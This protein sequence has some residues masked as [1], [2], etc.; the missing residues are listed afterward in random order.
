M[1]ERPYLRLLDIIPKQMKANL[2]QSKQICAAHAKKAMVMIRFNGLI[3]TSA[4]KSALYKC[5][6]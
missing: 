6:S 5:A 1:K 2:H 4:G 3:A